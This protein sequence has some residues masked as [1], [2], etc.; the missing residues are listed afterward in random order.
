[1]LSFIINNNI[2]VETFNIIESKFSILEIIRFLNNENDI[3]MYR[4]PLRYT[5]P[6][7]TT[8]LFNKY[9]SNISLLELAENVNI[10][11][12]MID[13]IFKKV[14]R[15]MRNDMEIGMSILLNMTSKQM[16]EYKKLYLYDGGEIIHERLENLLKDKNM[17]LEFFKDIPIIDL[18]SD[19]LIGLYNSG[20]ISLRDIIMY[21]ASDDRY[22]N[23]LNL[24]DLAA[25]SYTND[26]IMKKLV[27][28][29]KWQDIVSDEVYI[30]GSFDYETM[31]HIF[32]TDTTGRLESFLENKNI[33]PNLLMKLELFDEDGNYW[34]N[35]C[36]NKVIL[37]NIHIIKLDNKKV[38]LNDEQYKNILPINYL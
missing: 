27:F 26:R 21:I 4:A 16:F 28:S 1:M 6:V 18:N 3:R 14:G 33:F 35:L 36:Q 31:S 9:V 37:E 13:H 29:D 5:N 25:S 38:L 30:S 12:K 2:S 17:T 11:S 22:E 8:Y 7:I 23:L 10:T 32:R 34:F 15:K 24:R 19:M 20:G